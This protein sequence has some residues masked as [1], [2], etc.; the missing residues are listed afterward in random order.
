MTLSEACKQYKAH[1]LIVIPLLVG[2]YFRVVPDMVS[3]WAKD[4]NYSHG[5]LVP[6]IAGYFLWHRWPSLKDRKVSPNSYGLVVVALGGVQLLM[7]WLASEYFMMR[8]SLIVVLVGLVLFWFGRDILKWMALPLGYL[9]FMV[10]IPYIIYDMLAFPLKLFVT[11]VSV[12]FLRLVGVIVLREGNIIM[13]PSTTLEV[14]DA[15]SGIRSL[16][17]LLALAVAY[18][19]FVQTSNVRRWFI[20]VAAVPVAIATNALRVIITGFLAQWWGAKA[21]EGFFHEFAGM[22]VFLLAIVLLVVV[23]L[24]VKGRLENVE[25]AAYSAIP[26]PVPTATAEPA[27]APRL[28]SYYA[29]FT[30]LFGVAL[31]INLHSDVSV[32]PN[33][34]F[35]EFPM[36]VKAWQMAGQSEFSANVLSV[37]KPTDYL[38]RQ[39]KNADGKVVG[40][41]IGFHGGGKESGEIHSPRNCLPGS[42]WY[43]ISAKRGTLEIPSGGSVKLVRSVYQKGENKELFLYWFQARG[44]SMNDEFSLKLAEMTGSLFYRRRDTSFIRVS[45]PFEGDDSSALSRGE[46]FV[47]DITPTIQEFLPQ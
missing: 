3:D 18:A 4:D 32:P 11:K 21:A 10:P 5:F 24:L 15:C 12:G 40:L 42:G 38:Y 47:R 28:Q 27:P 39:Y 19:F 22:V 23:G 9:I 34:P 7:G 46:Q 44:H 37:L 26:S 31:F 8:S 33:R 2:L 16:M 29:V 45:V 6:F 30:L 13:F 14:A 35:N 43:E 17:S 41:Y 1:F 25:G 36:Q 20:I